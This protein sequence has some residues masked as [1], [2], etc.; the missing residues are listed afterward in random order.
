MFEYYG[1]LVTGTPDDMLPIFFGDDDEPM[2][3]PLGQESGERYHEMEAAETPLY[4]TDDNDNQAEGSIKKEV[5]KTY[6]EAVGRYLAIVI[7][8]FLFAMQVT[9]NASDL[10]LAH[11]ISATNQVDPTPTPLPP[12]PGT[13]RVTYLPRLMKQDGTTEDY[14]DNPEDDFITPVPPTNVGFLGDMDPQVRRYFI[15]FIAIGI[16]NSFMTL[17][18]AFFF[19]YGSIQGGKWIHKRLI[20]SVLKVTLQFLF[21]PCVGRCDRI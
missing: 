6:M 20:S 7:L 5:Y 4:K 13:T 1:C 21:H 19:A 11:W 10:W 3:H 15:V 14:Y 2:L 8:L 16:I 12:T 9:R 18:R 17:G